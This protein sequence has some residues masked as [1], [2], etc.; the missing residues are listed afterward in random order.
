MK[1]F[2]V[3]LPGSGKTTLGKQ[4]AQRLNVS[5]IDLDEAIEEISGKNVKEIFSTEGETS[6]REKESSIL[7]Q[8][9]QQENDFVMATGGGA[10]C[11]HNGIGVMNNAGVTVFLDVSVTAIE[12]HMQ[13]EEKLNRPLLATGK[14]LT[15]TLYDLRT[16][17]LTHYQQAKL[18]VQGDQLTVD[19]IMKKLSV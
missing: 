7:H 3:G 19:D 5:F 9:I 16:A 17:R 12:Q 15:E 11:F 13:E 6:F 2:L 10:P 4:L 14:S 8:L 1:I 18:L